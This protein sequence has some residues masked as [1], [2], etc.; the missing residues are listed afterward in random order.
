MTHKER[1][2]NKTKYIK[3]TRK[4]VRQSDKQKDGPEDGQSG[5]K[6]KS[7]LLNT[8]DSLIYNDDIEGK[9]IRNDD[10]QFE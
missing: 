9:L 3:I 8:N 6:I 10:R 5:K 2:E 4:Y 1:E 7:E